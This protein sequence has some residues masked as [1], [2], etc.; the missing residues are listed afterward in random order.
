MGLPPGFKE[1]DYVAEVWHVDLDKFL[2][3]M[4]VEEYRTAEG[5]EF[6]SND[7]LHKV[8]T[9]PLDYWDE[10]DV[11]ECRRILG[12]D[13]DQTEYDSAPPLNVMFSVL[14]DMGVIPQGKYLINVMW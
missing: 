13:K 5:L 12:I 6:P 1:V 4:C 9:Q 8:S 7:T 14:A 3:S 10:E 11:K 2:S